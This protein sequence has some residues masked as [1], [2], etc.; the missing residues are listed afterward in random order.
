MVEFCRDYYLGGLPV[1]RSLLSRI[2]HSRKKIVRMGLGGLDSAR[3]TCC[4]EHSKICLRIANR[5]FAGP[6]FDS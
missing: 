2:F 4:Q 1:R 6:L 3:L 5:P